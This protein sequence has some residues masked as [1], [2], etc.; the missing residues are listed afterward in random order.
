MRVT[1]GPEVGGAERYGSSAEEDVGCRR[2]VVAFPVVAECETGAV[3]ETD[4][5][6]CCCC[7]DD[8]EVEPDVP[9]RCVFAGGGRGDEEEGAYGAV[10]GS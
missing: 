3:R 4:G 2:A 7:C 1:S 5:W 10:D 6:C 8:V 9:L